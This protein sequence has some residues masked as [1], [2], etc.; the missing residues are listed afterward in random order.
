MIR[1]LVKR[2]LGPFLPWV[3]GGVGLIALIAA[4]TLYDLYVDDPAVAKAAREGYVLE[5]EKAALA[6]ELDEMQRQR[7]VANA[8][9]YS[10]SQK[11]A[12]RAQL[13]L[14]KISKLEDDI[15]GYEAQLLKAGRSC[16]LTDAD[17][18]WLRD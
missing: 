12:N 15:H 16:G 18:N 1:A 5:A 2:V 9:L 4:L 10:F 7:D 8:A 3:V 13:N 11:S 14:Q 17:I 6:A